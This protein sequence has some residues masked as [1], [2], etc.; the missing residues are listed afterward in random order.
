MG[1]DAD[2]AAAKSPWELV[3]LQGPAPLL[4]VHVT[5]YP[6]RSKSVAGLMRPSAME[7][8]SSRAVP[9]GNMT[10]ASEPCQRPRSATAFAQYTGQNMW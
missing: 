7:M 6:Q 4:P 9:G 1:T 5:A 8:E 10:E 3:R 2:F